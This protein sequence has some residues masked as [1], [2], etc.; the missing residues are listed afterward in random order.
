MLPVAGK[1]LGH[2]HGGGSGG[3][4]AAGG[5]GGLFSGPGSGGGAAGGGRK[6]DANDWGYASTAGT[7]VG[8][9]AAA[10]DAGA[11]AW[12]GLSMPD[13]APKDV[14]KLNTCMSCQAGNA[15]HVPVHAR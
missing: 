15:G 1:T 14:V 12:P 4:A 8:S 9:E 2:R 11:C 3:N 13:L 10:G 7:T 6:A 5:L